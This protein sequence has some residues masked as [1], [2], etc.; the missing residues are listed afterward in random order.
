MA[1]KAHRHGTKQ[2][3]KPGVVVGIH[4]VPGYMGVEENKTAD[5]VAK[6]LAETRDTRG[7]PERFNSLAYI[8]GTVRERK[9][10]EA[11]H[12]FQKR[13]ESCYYM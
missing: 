1:G 5:E 4:W 13:H 7:Y 8:G 6:T 11:K 2:L 3:K 10:K 12:L 9:W